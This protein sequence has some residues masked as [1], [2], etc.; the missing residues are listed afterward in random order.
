MGRQIGLCF[1]VSSV[2]SLD[3]EQQELLKKV[4]QSL[5]IEKSRGGIQFFND[6]SLQRSIETAPTVGSP[7][8]INSSLLTEPT[9]IAASFETITGY[10]LYGLLQHQKTSLSPQELW[11]FSSN[12]FS[13]F[14]ESSATNAFSVRGTILRLHRLQVMNTQDS[15][16]IYDGLLLEDQLK[17]VDLLSETKLSTL[18]PAGSDFSVKVKSQ[19]PGAKYG[20]LTVPILWSCDAE[21]WGQAVIYFHITVDS[22]G[23]ILLPI[24]SEV[25]GLV[26]P[27]TFIGG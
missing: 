27:I 13:N 25:R 22:D 3:S 8:M 11:N 15:S 24:E 14:R 6:P 7:L 2:C 26:K 12:V 19:S 17:T 9:G 21:N 23:L 5:E 18:C 16:F 20:D 10:V 4:Y 1:A